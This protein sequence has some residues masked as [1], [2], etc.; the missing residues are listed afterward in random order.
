M[1]KQNT[2]H[3]SLKTEIYTLC[4][5]KKYIESISIRQIK[6]RKELMY[7]VSE[8]INNVRRE[9]YVNIAIFFFSY[10]VFKSLPRVVK[11][12]IFR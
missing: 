11:T 3:F 9:K 10:N 7:V 2:N 12:H 5:L 8:R 1:V 6:S 4:P